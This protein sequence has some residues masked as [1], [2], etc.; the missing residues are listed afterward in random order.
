MAR[1]A[2]VIQAEAENS[3]F[4]SNKGHIDG[5]NNYYTGLEKAPPSVNYWDI[6]DGE[7][8]LDLYPQRGGGPKRPLN[9]PFCEGAFLADDDPLFHTEPCGSEQDH[10]DKDR[11]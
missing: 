9:P 4:R 7:M 10:Q 11:M 1:R 8:F 6:F 2:L 5:D 3:T